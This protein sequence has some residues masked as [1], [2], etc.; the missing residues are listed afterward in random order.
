MTTRPFLLAILLLAALPFSSRGALI[1]SEVCFNEVG[2]PADGEWIEIF[3]N[4]ASAITLTDYKIGDEETM[5]GTGATEAMFK[6]PVGASI[7]PGEVQIVSGG[8]TR[9]NVVYGKFPTYEWA[10][11]EAAIPDMLPY[12]TWDPDGGIINMSNTD[13]QAV[14]L[15]PTD[16]IIDKVSWGN[17]F[18]FNPA[19]D[20]TGN[21]DGQ[22]IERI[23][24]YVD[25]DTASDWRLGPGTSPAASRSTPGTVPVPEPTTIT[26]LLSGCMALANG[27]RARHTA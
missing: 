1:I 8:A 13:D 9:F 7:A 26:L 25:T 12:A 20:I 10:A 2:S 14:L 27:R 3:N 22:S 11:E 23:N 24:P 19:V 17:T 4:G 15:D 5:N 16:K 6:F 18:A 21:L